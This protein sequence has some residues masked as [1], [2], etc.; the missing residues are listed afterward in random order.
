MTAG[1]GAPTRTLA[2]LIQVRDFLSIHEEFDRALESV[3][4]NPREAVSAAA[5]TLEA[6]CKTYIEDEGLEM[7]TKQDL[8]SVWNVVRK[9]LGFDPSTVQDDDLRTILSGLISTVAGM[10]TCALMQAVPTLLAGGVIALRLDTPAWL[11][12]ARTPWR[13]SFWNPG[14]LEVPRW[15]AAE[16]E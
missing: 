13:R 2:E 15:L 3:G 6:I 8:P 14:M 5:N 9:H 7:P 16:L 1:L 12:T 10:G 4:S 11:F